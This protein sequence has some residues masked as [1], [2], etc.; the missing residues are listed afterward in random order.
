MRKKNRI[1]GRKYKKMLR[2]LNKPGWNALL[3]ILSYYAEVGRLKRTY[4]GGGYAKDIL[5]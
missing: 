5:P 1:K 2:T 4:F 3:K